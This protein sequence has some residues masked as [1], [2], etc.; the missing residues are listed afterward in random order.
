MS[1]GDVVGVINTYM[2]IS[3]PTDDLAKIQNQFWKSHIIL[4]K[5]IYYMNVGNVG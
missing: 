4:I 2:L 3:Q 5:M 1:T